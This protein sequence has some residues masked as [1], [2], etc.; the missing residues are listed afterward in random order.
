MSYFNE[1]SQI[2]KLKHCASALGEFAEA[3]AGAALRKQGRRWIPGR[4]NFVTF[5]VQAARNK[6]VVITLRGAPR[7]FEVE[8]ILPLKAE[9]S[10]RYSRCNF[11]SPSQLKA[12]AK[13]IDRAYELYRRGRQR[14]V[15]T[16]VTLE[17]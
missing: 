11:N 9:R 10:G 5:Q 7:E 13:Y 16:P 17:L 2:P 12:A 1:V 6:D 4:H 8:E 15:T 14:D 3:L